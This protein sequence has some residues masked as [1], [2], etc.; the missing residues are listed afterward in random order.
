MSEALRKYNF[1][2]M[3]ARMYKDHK[4]IQANNNNYDVDDRRRVR[5]I[6]RALKQFIHKAIQ[7]HEK[8]QE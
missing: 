5:N 7:H 1:A 4:T 8:P 3:V 2:R 6:M